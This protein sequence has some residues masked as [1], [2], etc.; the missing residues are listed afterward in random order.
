MSFCSGVLNSRIRTDYAVKLQRS[1]HLATP[2]RSCMTHRQVLASTVVTV[3]HT[4]LTASAVSFVWLLCV[5]VDIVR[6]TA[7]QDFFSV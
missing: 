2:G 6:C 3:I 7:Q 4:S 5:C 1:S